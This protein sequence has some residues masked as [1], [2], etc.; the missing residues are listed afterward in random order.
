TSSLEA[1]Q[2]LSLAGPAQDTQ[3]TLGFLRRAVQLDPN[4]AMAYWALGIAYAGDGENL[5]GRESMRRAFELRERVT[6]RERLHIETDYYIV[7]TGDL[8]AAQHTCELGQQL[9]PR[10][11]MFIFPLRLIDYALGQHEEGIKESLRVFRVTTSAHSQSF[12]YHTL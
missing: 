11:I 7:A 9:Y 1:L 2:A 8:L 10:D 6:D 4:F 3:T 5:L 12:A